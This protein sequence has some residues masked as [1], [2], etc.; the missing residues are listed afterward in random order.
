MKHS[1]T[2]LLAM[3]VL[4]AWFTPA[5]RGATDAEIDQAIQ[6][7]LAWLATQQ[8][9][10]G[11]FGSGY[12][13][14]NT[15]TAVLAFEMAMRNSNRYD[16]IDAHCV[17]RVPLAVLNYNEFPKHVDFNISST[18]APCEQNKSPPKT[19]SQNH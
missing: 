7:G 17:S 11:S 15:A 4:L 1:L 2:L 16:Y 10:D 3:A 13:L 14:A 19:N 5:A 12:Y 6:D 8:K 18:N 9:A